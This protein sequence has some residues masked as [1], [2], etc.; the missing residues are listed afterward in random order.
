MVSGIPMI[1]PSTINLIRRFFA[2][3]MLAG[4][5]MAANSIRA[6]EGR[7]TEFFEKKVR[8]V[9]AERCYECH[10]HQAKKLKANLHLDSREG[11]LKGG[12]TGVALVLGE[13]DKS[14][15]IEAIC[16]TN[17]DL[18]M[19]PKQKLSDATIADLVE[20]VKAGAP[21]PKEEPP[22]IVSSGK[23][24]LEQQK[25]KREH[26]AWQ[27]IRSPK[28]PAVKNKDQAQNE[29]DLFILARLEERGL[30]PVPAADRRTLIRRAYFDLIGLPPGAEEVESFLSDDSPEA[31]AKVVDRL[32]A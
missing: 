7:G 28:L 21:W 11:M 22:R 29:I 6:A 30:V 24:N 10:S 3:L 5:P 1:E 31:F 15:I 17:T 20:W 8:P 13:P 25:R 14:R 26:W 18:Q 32:L 12:D 23:E 19:P 4:M 27:P 9:L 2:C 16:Y